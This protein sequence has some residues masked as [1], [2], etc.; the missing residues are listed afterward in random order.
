[1]PLSLSSSPIDSRHSSNVHKYGF[2]T[3]MKMLLQHSERSIYRYFEK[4]HQHHHHIG[5]QVAFERP[6]VR[7]YENRE[8]YARQIIKVHWSKRNLYSNIDWRRVILDCIGAL[9]QSTHNSNERPDVDVEVWLNALWQKRTDYIL[10]YWSVKG[11]RRYSIM[12]SD[13][14]I[15]GLPIEFNHIYFT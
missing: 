10:C 5:I 9:R 6:I 8:C 4:S 7:G 1:M 2:Y 12:S 11:M 14:V 13:F 15:Y 3:I